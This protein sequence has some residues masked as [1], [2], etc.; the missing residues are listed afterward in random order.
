[1]ATRNDLLAL[2]DGRLRREGGR[3]RVHDRAGPGPGRR[4]Q[5]G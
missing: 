1:M 3:G 2:D 5:A 4:T